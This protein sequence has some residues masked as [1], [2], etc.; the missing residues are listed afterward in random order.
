M[1]RKEQFS[2]SALRALFGWYSELSEQSEQGIELDVIA[3]CC[4]W[5]EYEEC[6]LIEDFGEQAGLYG[7]D[8]TIENLI[9]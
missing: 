7:E 2:Y 9:D 8:A 6:D 5:A 3:I 1:G 4:E